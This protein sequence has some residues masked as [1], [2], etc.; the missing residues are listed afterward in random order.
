MKDGDHR[1]SDHRLASSLIKWLVI[2]LC[3][4]QSVFTVPDI[5]MEMLLKLLVAFVKV[6]AENSTSAVVTVLL[7]AIPTSIYRL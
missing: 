7:A 6:I 5:A 1:N 4:W 2:F 3:L